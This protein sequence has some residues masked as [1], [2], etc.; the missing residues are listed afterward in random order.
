MYRKMFDFTNRYSQVPVSPESISK[1][2]IVTKMGI[3][4]FRTMPFGLV[5]ASST[6]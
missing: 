3:H 1:K 2:S 4:Q 6:F 5:G